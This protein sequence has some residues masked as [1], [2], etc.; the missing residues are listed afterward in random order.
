MIVV[1]VRHKT[2]KLDS[3]EWPRATVQCCSRPL[4]QFGCASLVT[5][6]WSMQF[7]VSKLHF[8]KTKFKTEVL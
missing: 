2:L 4:S 8:K 3:L 5:A 7:L 6:A 1:Y